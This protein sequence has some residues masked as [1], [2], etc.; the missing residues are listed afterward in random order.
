M[1]G[2]LHELSVAIG[3]LRAD[4]RDLKD[5]VKDGRVA[6]SELGESVRSLEHS[7]TEMR[8]LVADYRDSRLRD[9]GASEWRDRKSVV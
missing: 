7:V 8:P 1:A 2:E 4:V 6:V 5:V 3:E 9:K